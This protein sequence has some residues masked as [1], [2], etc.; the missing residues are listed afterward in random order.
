M[1]SSTKLHVEATKRVLRYLKGTVNYH[2]F[3]ERGGTSDLLGFTNSDYAGDM[4]DNK[5]TSGYVFMM[6]GSA[7]TWSSRKQPI[8]TLSAMEAFVAAA[9][10]A[11]QAIWMR[12]VLKEI[13][14]IQVE[15]TMLLCDNAS[16]I[17]L[18][19]NPVLHGRSKHIRVRC[20]NP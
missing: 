5:T 18:S 1:A 19:K 16:T 17:K 7:V 6:C 2:V 12:R 11:C 9:A 4:E 10:C 3:Y 15:G 8:V 13:S 14:H 20:N